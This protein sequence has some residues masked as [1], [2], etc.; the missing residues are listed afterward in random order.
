LIDDRAVVLERVEERH[1]EDFVVIGLLLGTAFMPG[2][3]NFEAFVEAY[4]G[5]SDG[6]LSE[7]GELNREFLE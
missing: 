6:F 4:R 7:N 5:V 2:A 3:A 1:I